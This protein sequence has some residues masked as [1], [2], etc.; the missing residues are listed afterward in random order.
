MTRNR[1]SLLAPAVLAALALGALAPAQ[2]SA[3]L[4]VPEIGRCVKV[5]AGTGEYEVASCTGGRKPTGGHYDWEKASKIKFVAGGG[6]TEIETTGGK[7]VECT[8]MAGTGEYYAPFPQNEEIDVKLLGCKENVFHFECRNAAPEEIDLAMYG[9]YGFIK[10]ALNKEGKLVVSVGMSLKVDDPQKFECGPNKDQ[11][12]IEEG[13]IAPV[14]PIDKMSATTFT[15]KFKA[16]AGKQKPPR[17]EGGGL[18]ALILDET[19]PAMPPEQAGL[20][21]TIKNTNEEA[22]EIKAKE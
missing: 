3:L 8:V 6:L 11:Y 12:R 19:F 14:T 10:N 5:A 4:G 17:F 9:E 13:V 2:S 16:S 1:I 22:M 21:G 7:K 15:F 20:T 18:E